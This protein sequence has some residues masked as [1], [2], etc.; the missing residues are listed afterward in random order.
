MGKE[1]FL[2]VV[3]QAHGLLEEFRRAATVHQ[4]GFRPEHLGHFRQHRGASLRNQIVGKHAQQRIG[5]DAGKTVGATAFQSHA[6]LG[7]GHIGTLVLTALGI[8]FTQDAHAFLVFIVHLLRHQETDTVFVIR[9]DEFPKHVGLVVLASQ[10]YHQHGSGIGMQHHVAQNLLRVLM[11]FAQ[12]RTT[13]VM[14]ESHDGIYPL[15][16]VRLAAESVGQLVHDTVHAAHGRD[17]P[18]L[19]AYSHIT[20]AAAVALERAMLHGD[21]RVHLHRRVGIVQQS[22]QIGLDIFFAHPGTF[23]HVLHHVTD[24]V[25]VFYDIFSGTEILQCHLVSGRHV[26]AKRN[27]ATVCLNGLSRTKGSDGHRHIVGRIDSQIS[28][29]HILIT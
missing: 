28:C 18:N 27:S 2:E 17:N 8:Q 25:A 5:R 15:A 10:T 11:V 13:V 7:E 20:V 23:G 21:V 12:L 22:R 16:A 6:Q 26:R 9:A 19:V 24:G 29:F 4:N 3:N 14:G 1:I